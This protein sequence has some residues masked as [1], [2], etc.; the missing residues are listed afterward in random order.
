MTVRRIRLL[1]S[2]AIVSLSLP[3]TAAG[4]ASVAGPVPLTIVDQSFNVGESTTMRFTFSAPAALLVDRTDTV[5]V[6][7]HRRVATRDSLVGLAEGTV[8]TAVTDTWS[9]ALSD[10]TV[11]DDRVSFTVRTTGGAD[12]VAALRVP[13]DGVYPLSLR[14]RDRNTV[15]A[16]VLTFIHRRTAETAALPKST[17]GVLV[18]LAPPPSIGVDGRTTVNDAVRAETARFVDFVRGTP[19]GLTVSVR[20][21]TV[22]ALAQSPS[23]AALLSELAAVLRERTV[24][25]TAFVPLDPSM[26][27]ATGMQDEF[28]DQLRAGED[29][30]NRLLPGVPIQRGTWIADSP[31]SAPAVSLLRRAGI[32][33]LVLSPGAQRNLNAQAPLSVLS[34]PNAHAGEFISVVSVDQRAARGIASRA[35]TVS[36]VQAGYRAAAELIIECDMLTASGRAP[37]SLRILLSTMG[38]TIPADGSIGVAMNAL[39]G[40]GRFAIRDLAVPEQVGTST[41]VI[42]FPAS[43]ATQAAQRG[44]GIALARSEFDATVSMTAP[45]DPRRETWNRMLAIGESSVP[46][47][48]TYITGVRTQLALARSAVSVNTPRTITLS[49]RRGTVRIQLRNNSDQPLTVRVRMYSAKLKI[50]K[51][52]RE[53]TLSPSG[54]TEVKVDASTRTNGRFPISVRVTTPEG[55]LEVVPYITITAK[56]TG[57]AGLGQVVGISL[58]LIVLAWWWSHWR[59]SRLAA[60]GASTVPRQ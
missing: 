22:A 52:S 45:D 28:I 51:P 54:M 3:V 60:S 17:A 7:L 48:A 34:R 46:G 53:V 5:E 35:T 59:R 40:S 30:L 9:V 36:G 29:T 25:T 10:T 39:A 43:V 37:R 4:A 26:F 1:A 56:M 13:F 8:D 58:L 42:A 20:P 44:G 47:A 21:E 11:V 33:A 15:T 14:L 49:D 23:D 50:D 31:L 32:V 6:Q 57:F 24:P 27:V 12:S 55:R 2:A 41:P 16:S 18:R 19:I 38:G